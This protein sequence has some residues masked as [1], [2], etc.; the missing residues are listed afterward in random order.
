MERRDFLRMA[1]AAAALAAAPRSSHAAAARIDVLINEPIGTIVPDIYGHFVEHLGGVVYDGVWVGEGSKIPNTHGIRQAL[2][3]AMRK[4]PKGA[5]RWP[6]GC[7]ADSYDW[8]DGTGPREQRARRTNFWAG[9]TGGAPVSRPKFDPNHFGSVDFARFC[10][11]VGS[12]PY[13]AANLR[14]LPARDF[15]Q[16]VEYCNSPAGTTSLADLRARDGEK[17]PL[18]VRY[19]G[20]GNESWGCGGDF[21]AEEYAVEFRRFTSWVPGFDTRLAF[22]ASGP[23]S[24]DLNWTRGFFSKL[25]EKGPGMIGRVAG[26]ALH[27]YTENLSFGDPAKNGWDAR[28]GPAVGF[29]T[30]EWYEILKEADRMEHLITSHWAVIGEFD[31][32]RAVKLFVDEWGTWFKAGTEARPDHLLGQQSTMRDAVV[33]SLTFDTFHRHADKVA[34]ANIAQLVNCLQSPF[35][36]HED[37]FVTTPTYHVFDLYGPH[38]GGQAVRTVVSAPAIAYQRPKDTGSVLGLSGSASVKDK[39]LTLTVTNPHISEAQEVEIA[40]RGAASGAV[41]GAQLAA[42]DVQTHNTFANP[43]AVVIK[44]ATVAAVQNGVLVHRFPPASVTRLQLTLS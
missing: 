18:K 7:F 29:S 31:R 44:D 5:M 15:Y 26:F 27:H 33:A 14:S 6:G 13:F 35:I 19:W 42:P 40:V 11:L 25:T 4:L 24:G 1:A 30:A 41:R 10:R 32:R 20:V 16:W 17:D 22:I 36:A 9:Q 21:T 39:T 38:A 3:D 43:N 8:R 37:Q 28:K 34:M 12:E 2:I 23:S